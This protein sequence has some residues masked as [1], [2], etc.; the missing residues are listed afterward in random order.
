MGQAN[1]TP[2]ANHDLRHR[3][4][5]LQQRATKDALSG[6]LNRDT[7]ELCIKQ[8]LAEMTPEDTC[9]LFIVDLDDF[10]KVNDTLGHQ[11]G[12]QAIRK[13][14]Q[15]LSGLFRANDIVGRLGGDEFAVF[16]CGQITEELARETGMKICQTLQLALGDDPVVDLTA[17][18]GIYLSDAG[19]QFEGLYQS[20]DL[21]LYKAKKAGKHGFCLKSHDPYQEP[22]GNAF[23]PVNT[24]PLSGLLKDM[25]SGVALLEMG[26]AP[27]VL[28][29]S[30]SFCRII[31]IDPH[32]FH[33][34]VPLSTL[35]HPDDL[36]S[37]EQALREG[38]QQGRPVEHTHRVISGDGEHWLW[39]HIRAVGIDYDGPD[40]VMMVTTTDISRFKESEQRLEEINQRLQTAFDQTTQRVW[41]VDLLTKTFTSFD[42]DGTSR[43]L[44][45]QG[46]DFSDRLVDS[47]WIHPN[48][49]ARFR[50][51]AQELLRGRSQGYGHFIL[52]RQD[53]GSYG[54]A[55]LSY[56]MI[57][58]DAGQAVRAVGIIED[59]AKSLSEQDADAP[60]R[61]PLPEG[62]LAD[63]MV[64]IRADLTQDTVEALW[65][66][67]KDLSGQV[68]KISCSTILSQEQQKILSGADL[69]DFR[70]HYGREPLLQLFREGR[71]WLCAEYPR[72]DGSGNIRWVRHAVHL[73]Q[74]LMSGDT[75]VHI[76]IIRS[77]PLG[78]LE[79]TL[80]RKLV[81]DT[82]TQ[83]FAPEMAE[84]IAAALFPPRDGGSAAWP[85]SRSPD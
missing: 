64:R 44:E 25:G 36:P 80:G 82:V 72:A 48:S 78:Q 26:R 79:R 8:R 24:I 39:W 7:V 55:A 38:L 66:E 28:Y 53:T 40:P 56:R 20:A 27:Q 13:S 42:R 35:I 4:E 18:V 5:E 23:R 2:S 71:R 60:L 43:I 57:F 52:R 65:A 76:Y 54:W 61:R 68:Q 16:L 31:G 14:A 49:A 3:F 75:L 9:A 37:L 62:L 15:L 29:V 34:P 58:D 51:F 73:T 1:L 17:S 70:A 12:D 21:A 41:E 22:R 83:L 84:K 69:E 19:Q 74:D 45:Y 33:L 11:A 67:G 81:Q 10:K 63:L 30:P 77:D 46:A 85:C 32:S 50:A 6:L 59:L 47:G